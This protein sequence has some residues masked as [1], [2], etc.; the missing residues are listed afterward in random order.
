MDLRIDGTHYPGFREEDWRLR[1]AISYHQVAGFAGPDPFGHDEPLQPVHDRKSSEQVDSGFGSMVLD[2]GL[3]PPERS[4]EGTALPADFEFN[5]QLDCTY[6]DEALREW[7]HR[8]FLLK[9]GKQ[10]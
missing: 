5:L 7:Q 3:P 6:M 9:T 10:R 4:V 8:E 2:D 1:E